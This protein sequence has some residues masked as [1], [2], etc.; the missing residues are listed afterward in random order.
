[1]AASSISQPSSLRKGSRLKPLPECSHCLVRKSP[2]GNWHSGL[3]PRIGG[4]PASAGRC[5]ERRRRGGVRGSPSGGKYRRMISSPPSLSPFPASNSHEIKAGRDFTEFMIGVSE[6]ALL[7]PARAVPAGLRRYS[8]AAILSQRN[9]SRPT[10]NARFMRRSFTMCR[11]TS[12]TKLL[13]PTISSRL[14]EASP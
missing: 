9:I 10:P 6:A 12:G 3:S 5:P 8:W 1:M 7:I 11:S 4:L 13:A 2:A 14:P